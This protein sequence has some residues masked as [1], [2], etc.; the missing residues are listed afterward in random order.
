MGNQLI[1]QKFNEMGAAVAFEHRRPTRFQNDQLI[2]IDVVEGRK[3]EQA[4]K[5]IKDW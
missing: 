3:G 4:D 5:G 1:K 2:S